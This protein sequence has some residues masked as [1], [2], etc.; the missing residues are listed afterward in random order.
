VE[1]NTTLTNYF[2]LAKKNRYNM[3]VLPAEKIDFIK[4]SNSQTV[5]M[6]YNTSDF[7]NYIEDNVHIMSIHI[8]NGLIKEFEKKGYLLGIKFSLNRK[9]LFINKSI[10]MFQSIDNGIH[11]CLD[12][13]NDWKENSVFYRRTFL[14]GRIKLFS[15]QG[16]FENLKIIKQVKH[17]E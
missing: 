12:G 7:N 10:E 5:R 15:A 6:Y 11:G 2:I 9:F 4:N 16:L 14:A 17:Q 8:E 13:F 3:Y 1:K